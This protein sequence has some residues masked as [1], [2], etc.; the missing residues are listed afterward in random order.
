MTMLS[1]RNSRMGDVSQKGSSPRVWTGVAEVNEGELTTSDPNHAS[2][3]DRKAH[4]HGNPE[5]GPAPSLP[6]VAA[7][8]TNQEDTPA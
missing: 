4:P 8:D 3:S 6:H 7:R 1:E 5:G 2:R